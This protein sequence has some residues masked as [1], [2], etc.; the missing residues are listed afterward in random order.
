MENKN[1]SSPIFKGGGSSVL[2]RLRKRNHLCQDHDQAK[3]LG[4]RHN[5]RLLLYRGSEKHCEEGAAIRLDR[6]MARSLYPCIFN[7]HQQEILQ[8]ALEECKGSLYVK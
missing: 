4:E 2:I 8:E 7:K 1:P 5:T 3:L 6:I